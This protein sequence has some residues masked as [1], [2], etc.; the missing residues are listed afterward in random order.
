MFFVIIVMYGNQM[1][2]F[3]VIINIVHEYFVNYINVCGTMQTIDILLAYRNITLF[4]VIGQFNRSVY[5]DDTSL[6]I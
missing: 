3:Y 4:Q 1:R 2:A 6:K 5:F